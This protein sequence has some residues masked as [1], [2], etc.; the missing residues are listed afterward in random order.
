MLRTQEQFPAS[1]ISAMSLLKGSVQRSECI[2]DFL[3][4]FVSDTWWLF[5]LHSDDF[6]SYGHSCRKSSLRPCAETGCVS[7]AHSWGRWIPMWLFLKGTFLFWFYLATSGLSC[8]P[9]IKPASSGFEGEV[10]TTGS[11]GKSF[12]VLLTAFLSDRIVMRILKDF[13]LWYQCLHSGPGWDRRDFGQGRWA[14]G[15]WFHK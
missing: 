3:T 4:S 13:P 2:H 14:K 5:G 12:H 11:P 9:G 1:R 15:F 6:F 10:L 7:K 8:G